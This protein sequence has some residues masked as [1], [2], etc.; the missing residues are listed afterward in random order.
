MCHGR[1]LKVDSFR[2]NHTIWINEGGLLFGRILHIYHLWQQS[3]LLCIALE[4]EHCQASGP[5]IGTSCRHDSLAGIELRSAQVVCQKLTPKKHLRECVFWLY[6][7]GDQV[8][9]ASRAELL[10]TRA[11][12]IA[13]TDLA[14]SS[15][16]FSFRS[17]PG[18]R[19]AFVFKDDRQKIGRSIGICRAGS[20]FPSLALLTS[21]AAAAGSLKARSLSLDKF[22][23]KRQLQG[24]QKGMSSSQNKVWGPIAPATK[25]WRQVIG[26]VAPVTQNRLSKPEDL[27]L[28][29]ATPLRKSPPWSPNTSTSCV[30][31]TAPATRNASFQILFK[32]PTPANAF[33]TATKPSRFALTFGK[34]QNPLCRPLKSTSERPKVLRTPSVFSTFDFEMCFAPRRRALFRHLNF[35]KWSEPGVLC[36][37]W[38]GNVLRATQR[39]ALFR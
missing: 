36:T 22:V 29:N 16:K 3:L 14:S 7:Y 18:K 32:C 25:K 26:S 2:R 15:W 11:N 10:G 38:L 37:F 39:R 31:C 9:L 35:Q 1:S 34:V 30:S 19:H 5:A 4:W 33:E 8:R 13:R 20:T 27:M 21:R 23:W 17:W 24:Q 6:R 12:N 28:Q